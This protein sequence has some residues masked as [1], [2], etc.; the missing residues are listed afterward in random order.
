M[1]KTFLLALILTGAVLASYAG[2]DEDQAGPTQDLTPTSLR[3][4]RVSAGECGGGQVLQYLA[5]LSVVFV[6][7]LGRVSR[8]S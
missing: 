7:S 4:S 8:I 1:K 6:P 2:A 3:F 5:H